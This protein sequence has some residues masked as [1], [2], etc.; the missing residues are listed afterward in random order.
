MKYILDHKDEENTDIFC[1][2]IYD[3]AMISHKQLEPEAMTKFIER[4][5]K[6][7]EKLI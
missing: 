3:L 2:Q 4:S 7:L 1:Q 6:I 5:N